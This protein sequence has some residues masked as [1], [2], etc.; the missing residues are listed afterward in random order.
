[1]ALNLPNLLTILRIILIPVFMATYYVPT[2]WALV[3]TT[4]IFIFACLTDWLD[5]YLARRLRLESRFGAFLDPVADKLIVV[6]A[7]VMLVQSF[8][9]ALLTIPAIII[10]S[11]EIVISALRELMAQYGRSKTVAV[12]FVGK[13]KTFLQMTAIAILLSQPHEVDFANYITL[14][15]FVLLYVSTILTLWSML[16]YLHAAWGIL[17]SAD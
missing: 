2:S 16:K 4:S 7:L 1:M 10:V 17:R 3:L 13:L 9:T 5:G 6:V 8:G 12:A 15:G 14:A 11:R